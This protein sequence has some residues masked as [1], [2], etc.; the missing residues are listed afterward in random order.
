MAQTSKYD[1]TTQERA[2]RMYLERLEGG[3]IAKTAS[4][5]KLANCSV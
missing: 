3:D 1:V 2:V 5:E 4:S